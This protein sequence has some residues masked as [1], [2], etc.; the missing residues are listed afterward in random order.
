MMHDV[1]CK[2]TSTQFGWA[3]C[4]CP[5]YLQLGYQQSGESSLKYLKDCQF[6]LNL[7]K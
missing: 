5:D 1:L 7:Y 3:A 2:A 4:R 6:F